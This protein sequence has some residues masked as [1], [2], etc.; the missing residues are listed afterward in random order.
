MCKV[1]KKKIKKK[2]VFWIILKGVLVKKY[3]KKKFIVLNYPKKK[4]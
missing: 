2:Q 4:S 1:K 3:F